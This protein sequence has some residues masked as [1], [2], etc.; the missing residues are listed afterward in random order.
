[1]CDQICYQKTQIR[2]KHNK[3]DAGGADTF[4]Q[5]EK[6]SQKPLKPSQGEQEQVRATLIDSDQHS[7]GSSTPWFGL[8]CSCELNPQ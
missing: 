2:E 5:L 3:S 8:V 6:E 4:E 7:K 1:M